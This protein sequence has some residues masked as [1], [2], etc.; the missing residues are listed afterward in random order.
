ML[1][2]LGFIEVRINDDAGDF[3]A[4]CGSSARRFPRA[5]SRGLGAATSGF[6]SAWTVSASRD[7]APTAIL[8]AD[9]EASGALS[10]RLST[11]AYFDLVSGLTD[12]I[13][14]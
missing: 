11:R 9:L 4:S 6:S 10:R 2:D 8:F 3:S 1:S 13:D 12:L 7:A 14:S 5:C